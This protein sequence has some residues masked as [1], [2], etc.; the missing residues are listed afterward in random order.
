MK[1]CH[2]CGNS[3]A[4][5]AKFCAVCGSVLETGP[6]NNGGNRKKNE[7]RKKALLAG[8]ACLCIGAACVTGAWFVRAD[9]NP[10][11]Y[12]EAI[13]YAEKYLIDQEYGRA[14]EYYLEAKK[15]DPKQPEPYEGLY[16]IY[17]ATDQSEK[18]EE[19]EKEAH[20]NLE[21]ESQDAFDERTEE[22]DEEYT[23]V[24]SYKIIRDLGELD[25]VPINLNDEVWLIQKDGL[26]S[27]MNSD[28]GL[29]NQTDT[30]FA[31]LRSTFNQYGLTGTYEEGQRIYPVC[32]ADQD[33]Y[34]SSKIPAKDQWPNP[35]GSPIPGS[36]CDNG[37][38]YTA[39]LEFTLNDE[40]KPELSQRSLDSFKMLQLD[41]ADAA[42]ITEPYYLRKNNETEGEYYIWNPA[43]EE[44][45]G[46]YAEEDT[47]GFGKLLSQKPDIEYVSGEEGLFKH[48]V[49]SPFWS[50]AEDGES[51]ILHTV[52]GSAV[53]QSFDSALA[54]DMSSIGAFR[55]NLF[56][57]LDSQ[58]GTEYV[59]QFEAGA[60][61]INR[62]APV[63]IEGTWKLVEFGE[64]VRNKDLQV[65]E[66]DPDSQKESVSLPA[67]AAGEYF[68]S[69][70]A[71]AAG[72][73]MT[74]NRDG[75]FTYSESNAD[76]MTI[77]SIGVTGT[78]SP[79]YDE[80]GNLVSLV[81]ID[82][83]FTQEPG[84]RRTDENGME[85]I[86]LNRESVPFSTGTVIHYYPAGTDKSVLTG[87][88]LEQYD[89]MKDYMYEERPFL[90]VQ[91]GT[92][93]FYKGEM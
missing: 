81:V 28:G 73:S 84:T 44:V 79:E 62:I 20:E 86:T 41:P 17:V 27:F 49:L 25:M 37:M 14:E 31:A 58:L 57:L 89:F 9:N 55:K 76:Y 24:N 87:Y 77:Y 61:S 90:E 5:S 65:V 83:E 7:K 52:D 47:V 75:T 13:G 40:G 64:L 38:S 23:Y 4:D 34:S 43:A 19:I 70:G 66:A 18:A 74:V 1:L 85:H 60:K 72:V 26:F 16:E 71:G 91:G 39:S 32:L 54:T 33:S 8:L 93:F 2:N 46:P 42:V 69:S 48:L 10:E 21:Q 63:K 35:D 53:S 80:N 50:P 3:M 51:V 29:V 88:A 45:F 36:V 78:L 22:I 56:Y 30:E 6:E 92:Q 68:Y 12:A 67:E 15:I 11:K 59:G 82:M